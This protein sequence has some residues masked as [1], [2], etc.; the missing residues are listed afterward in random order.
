MNLSPTDYCFALQQQKLYNRWMNGLDSNGFRNRLELTC[1]SP[2]QYSAAD[3][4]MR[5]K[6]EVLQYKQNAALTTHTK[7][8][9]YSNLLKG[10]P[11]IASSR[12]CLS[13]SQVICN[14]SNP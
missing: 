14:P 6:A 11:K 12:T 7:A 8:Q 2:T 4:Q 9:K 5:R 1:V 10:R 3:L 13:S